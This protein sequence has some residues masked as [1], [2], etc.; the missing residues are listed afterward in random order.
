M[1]GSIQ[2]RNYEDNQGVKR[3]AVDIIVQ[4]CEFLSPKD[5]GGSFDAAPAPAA[6]KPVL[7]MMDDDG[8]D[9]PF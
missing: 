3:N 5:D 9:I 8:S 6:K 2:L 7:Q 4:D 1:G